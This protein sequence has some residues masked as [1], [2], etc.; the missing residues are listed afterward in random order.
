MI[1]EKTGEICDGL[2]S[3]GHHDL[4]AFLL[5]SETPTLFDAGMTFIGPLYFEE[6]KK[7]L[8]D[9]NR[10]GYNFLTH[11]HFDHC[12]ASPFLKR[13]I[14][15]LKVGTSKLATDI[16]KKPN[17]IKLIQSLNRDYEEKF[18]HLSGNE[19]I[20][21]DSME[22]DITLEDGDEIDLGGGW[23]VEV[24]ATPGHTRDSISYYIPRL[25][26]LI[27]GEAVGVY[28][29]NFN[30]HPEFLSSYNDYLTSLE[31]LAA[32]DVNVLMMA[33]HYIL[34]EEDA[35]GYIAKSIEKTKKF[36]KRIEDYLDMFNGEQE[37]VVKK[38]FKEDYEDTQAI[39]QDERPYLLNL[40]AK[41]K[42]VAEGK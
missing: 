26:G 15:G 28:D 40:N 6:L 39:K 23:K 32:L 27:T 16:L 2:Y 41:V 21:F 33:H 30:I 35:G 25:K 31:K 4:P 20:S 13:N 5:M 1:I 36:R 42:A 37:A 7:Y 19:D 9:A 14:K 34:T 18:K 3:I 22:I 12:G 11:S 24:I 29:S 8:G 10:L 38:I 17:A